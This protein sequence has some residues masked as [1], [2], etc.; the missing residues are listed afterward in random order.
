[1]GKELFFR[2]IFYLLFLDKL[3]FLSCLAEKNGRKGVAAML[4]TMTNHP[5]QGG[6][7]VDVL[8]ATVL[9]GLAVVVFMTGFSYSSAGTRENRE[10]IRAMMLVQDTLETLK[11]NDGADTLD[12]TAAVP[13]GTEVTTTGTGVTYPVT[14]NGIA[15]QLTLEEPTVTAVAAL[16][17]LKPVQLTVSWTEAA[18]SRSLTLVEY[19]YLK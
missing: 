12:L 6:G 16:T 1:M 14:E 17:K 8:V 4:F 15:Y 7:V 3:F 13:A 10:R 19:L 5:E 18:A 2:N 11:Q 9:L